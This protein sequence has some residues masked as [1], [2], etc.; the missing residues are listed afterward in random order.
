MNEGSEM[1]HTPVSSSVAEAAAIR[2]PSAWRRL[3]SDWGTRLCIVAIALYT[4]TA[5]YGEVVYRY[6]KGSLWEGAPAAL[7]WAHG[8]AGADAS[9]LAG[10]R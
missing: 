3:W 6:Y 8:S 9:L 10:L 4:L 2:G 5:L 1:T 7:T